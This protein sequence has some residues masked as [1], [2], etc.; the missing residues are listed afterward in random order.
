MIMVAVI[1][2]KA[3]IQELRSRLPHHQC[4]MHGEIELLE[5]IGSG[6]FGR[7]FKGNCRN[8]VVA[9]K[10]YTSCDLSLSLFFQIVIKAFNLRSF[11]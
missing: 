2:E 1:A 6:S 4:I 5:P 3:E 10:R 8:K 9:I 11:L 7:V